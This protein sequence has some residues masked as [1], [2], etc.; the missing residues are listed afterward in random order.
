M[1]TYSEKLKDP[2]WQKKRLEIFQRDNW[3][4]KN[5]GSK[6]KTLNVHHCWYYYGKKDPWEY[7]DKS[8]VT[9]CENCHKD[10]EKMRESAE[11]DLLTVLR[12]GGYTWLDIYEL[13]EL[14]LNAGKKLRM[15]DM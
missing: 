15:D 4:C 10:E 3:Q 7:D 13:T 8:L 9:L 6:E 12:Q 14:V 5:C 1:S 11:G 2:K